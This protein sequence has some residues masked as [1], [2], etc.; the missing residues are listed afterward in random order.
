MKIDIDRQ[1]E[2]QAKARKLLEKEERQRSERRLLKLVLD[3]VKGES[4]VLLNDELMENL[5]ELISVYCESGNRDRVKVLFE[6]LGEC[7]ASENPKLRERAVMAL[8]LCMGG[9]TREEHPDLMALVSAILLRWL[10]AE[11]VFLSVCGIVCKQLHENGIRMFEEGLWKECGVI[12]DSFSQIQSGVN[13][14]SNAIRSVVGRAQDAMATDYILEE[15]TLVC[16][17]GR[18]ERRQNAERILVN[19]GRKA[20]IHL[21]DTL[22]SCQEKEDRLRLIGLIPATGATAINVLEEYLQKK[23]PWYGIRNIILMITALDDPELIPLIMPCLSHEDIRIQ[24]QVIDCINEVSVDNPGRYLL[25]ALPVVD[26]TLKVGLIAYLGQLGGGDVT[27][28]FLDLLAKRD[29]FSDEVRDDLLQSLAVQVRLSNSIRAVN[30]LK[31]ILEE[32]GENPDLQKDHVAR[33][34]THSLQILQPRF[35][36]EKVST[37]SDNEVSDVPE[38]P[39]ESV[40]FTNDPVTRNHAKREVQKIN[41]EVTVLL[42]KGKPVDASQFLYEKCIEAAKEKKFDE[43]EMLRDRIL[44]VDP[45]ALGEVIKAGERIEEERSSAITSNHISIW[46]DLYDSLTTEEFKAL[47]Y[48][49]QSL[50]FSSGSVI[51]EQGANSPLLYFVN[52]GQARLT[53][54][55]GN[56]EV[57]LKK[58][59]PGEI[60]GTGPFF[61]VSIWTVAL[62]ALGT[63]NIHVLEREKFLDLLDQFPNIESCLVGFCSKAESVSKLLEMSGTDRRQYPRFPVSLLV[64]HILLDEFGNPSMRSFNGEIAD[65]SSGGLSFFIRISR[66]ENARLLL[67]RGIKTRLELKGDDGIE[68]VGV[69]VAVRYQ[70][71]A[72][73]DCSVHVEFKEL[74]A[75]DVVKQIVSMN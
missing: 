65:I 53:C 39:E 75:D 9:L 57:F 34:V 4:E 58:I 51:V 5:P 42:A 36:Q 50:D 20:A 19:L 12:L 18:G 32:R 55:R 35:K 41:E 60:I 46:Q 15:L 52:S 23:L 40:S 72:T 13:E 43:A 22:L 37:K 30:L 21:L 26:D 63:T 33:T 56:E 16:L 27:D 3:L 25:A 71:I 2:A 69:I 31:M 74:L 73:G 67:G 29:A 64:K 48:S 45:D 49:L 70:G 28:V 66:K 14:K 24:Q 11:T 68:S 7:A 54:W 8:S 1:N 17:R 6:K 47:Y 10:R 38:V 61:D 59:G 44:E 62:T